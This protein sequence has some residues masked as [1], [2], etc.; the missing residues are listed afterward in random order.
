MTRIP[1]Q[2]DIVSL[3]FDPQAGH[4]QQG[5]RPALVVSKDLFNESTGMIF[6]CPITSTE[7]GYPFHVALPASGKVT[8]FVMAEQMKSLDWRARKAR[9]LE[10]A[11]KDTLNEVLAIL[12][13]CIY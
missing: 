10:H 6:A 12:E 11:D 4:E 5:R 13:A 2:G 1:R 7:R 8:G 9:L 3:S